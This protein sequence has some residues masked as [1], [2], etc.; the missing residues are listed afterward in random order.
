MEVLSPSEQRIMDLSAKLVDCPQDAEEFLPL[1]LELRAA[2]RDHMGG[3]RRKLVVMS[4]VATKS[5][6]SR[7]AD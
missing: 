2:I 4:N 6:D 7:A 1:V 3:V 5:Q